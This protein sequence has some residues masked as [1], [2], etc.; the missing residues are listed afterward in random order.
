MISGMLRSL[1]LMG[2]TIVEA[3][4]LD[5]MF[6]VCLFQITLSSL[7]TKINQMK[8]NLNSQ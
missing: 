5:I 6:C 8:L 1:F 4:L 7:D 2:A 3:V